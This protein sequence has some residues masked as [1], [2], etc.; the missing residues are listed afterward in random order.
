MNASPDITHLR[1]SYERAELSESA[2]HTDPLQQFAQW[3]EEA[4]ASQVP[5]PNAMTP[6]AIRHRHATAPSLLIGTP[7]HPRPR[8]LLP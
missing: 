2:S 6:A 1:K 5:E 3:F 7:Q 8:Q 4:R